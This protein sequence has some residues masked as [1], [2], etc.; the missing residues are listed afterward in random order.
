MIRLTEWCNRHQIC[1]TTAWRWRRDGIFPHPTRKIGKIVFVLEDQ[2]EHGTQ[3]T[4]TCPKCG[5]SVEIEV[6]VK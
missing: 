3:L 1:Y 5:E 6:A 2:D 4:S